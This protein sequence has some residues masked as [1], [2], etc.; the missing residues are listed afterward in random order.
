MRLSLHIL[1]DFKHSDFI[2]SWLF[3]KSIILIIH[4]SLI[5]FKCA[6]LFLYKYFH[7]PP[8]IFSR[9]PIHYIHQY[10]I[11]LPI[12]SNI[13][14]SSVKE[15]SITIYFFGWPY[16]EPTYKHSRI[17]KSTYTLALVIA[18]TK[19]SSIT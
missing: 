3:A 14:L 17:A 6:A 1:L 10:K 15:S 12:Y 13:N 9:F 8:Q 11:Y 18:S 19:V 5:C 16:C 4:D 2:I 7:L